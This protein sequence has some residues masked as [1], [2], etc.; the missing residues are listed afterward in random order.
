[1]KQNKGWQQEQQAREASNAAA[2]ELSPTK[3]A[4][5]P[6]DHVPFTPHVIVHLRPA[7]LW[8][9]NQR[10]GE[11]QALLGNLGIWLTEQIRQ[12]SRFE[13]AEIEELTIALNFGARMALP[14]LAMVVRLKERQTAS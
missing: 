11:F 1:M 14:D 5:I 6:L 13:P 12:V 2:E 3:G 9:K 4:A 7:Q 8:Q 10:M